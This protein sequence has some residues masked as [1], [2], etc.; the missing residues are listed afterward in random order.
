[1][2]RAQYNQTVEQPKTEVKE[3]V[4]ES[5]PVGTAAAPTPAQ[6]P[7]KTAQDTVLEAVNAGDEALAEFAGLGNEEVR[8]D[9]AATPFIKI[10]QS[11]SPE[12]MP[13]HA[14]YQKG[15]EAG[16]FFHTIRKQPIVGPILLVDCFFEPLNIE[17]VPRS[18]GGG[19][20]KVYPGGDPIE[21]KAVR[22]ETEDGKK[23]DRLPNGNDLVRT[24]QHYFIWLNPES[25]QW[26]AVV[27]G[28]SST[29][30]THSRAL[31]ALLLNE[32]V[33]GKQ[34]LVQAP[35]FSRFIKAST[36]VERKGDQAWFG[37][38]FDLG[39]RITAPVLPEALG[40]TKLL[41]AGK[42]RSKPLEEEVDPQTGEV[43]PRTETRLAED[44]PL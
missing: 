24:A 11:N 8:V 9:D 41:M 19:M 34:G 12:C 6:L 42:R 20:V 36:A 21:Q 38:H 40:F 26:E 2:A 25:R 31:N 13:A 27:A 22:V 17:W 29:Q 33:L 28:L 18:K 35:R 32:K 1:M 16:M 44:T 30:L 4:A 7:A 23:V 15:C 5:P 37:W 10:L 3:G 43:R 39:P 14:K